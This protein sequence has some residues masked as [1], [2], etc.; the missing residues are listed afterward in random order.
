MNESEDD[1]IEEKDLEND[2]SVEIRDASTSSLDNRLNVKDNVAKMLNNKL[3]GNFASENVVN[4]SRW[5]LADSGIFLL[6]EGLNF[7]TTSNTINKAK[8]K[9]E[10]ETLDR[11]LRL[12]W[13]FRNEENKFDLDQFKPKSIFNLRNKDA[14]I[15]VYMSSLEEKLMKI[16]IPKDKYNNLTC[17]EW[18]ALYDFK[19]DES[20]VI[21]GSSKESTVVVW[22]RADYIKEAEKQLGDSD[23]YEEPLMTLNHLLAPYIERQKKNRKRVDL[24]KEPIKYFEVK[25]PKF[26][27]FCLLP[28]IHKQLNNVPGIPVISNCGYYTESISAF[29]DFHLQPLAQ[30]VKSYISFFTKIS[31]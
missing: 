16:E 1:V 14:A 25:D 29:L 26:A 7:V 31:W 18:Q 6:S 5:N 3:K 20:I 9:T 10:L 11:V 15:E 22:D 17:K 13:H 28:K 12:K 2:S 21:E 19:N 27:T 23:A 24:K 8:L 30:G 4:F